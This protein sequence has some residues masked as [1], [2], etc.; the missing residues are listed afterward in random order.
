MKSTSY[1]FQ[2]SV[3]SNAETARNSVTTRKCMSSKDFWYDVSVLLNG[4][5]YIDYD[6]VFDWRF[7]PHHE[8]E[9]IIQIVMQ[10]Q[11]EH[12]CVI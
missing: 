8:L 10:K 1:N 11:Y 9:I 4:L 7:H 2:K 6:S 3:L 12:V 5:A